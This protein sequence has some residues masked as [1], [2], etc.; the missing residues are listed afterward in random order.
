ME[1]YEFLPPAK[2]PTKGIDYLSKLNKV[3]EEKEKKNIKILEKALSEGGILKVFL[4]G[5]RLRI[6]RIDKNDKEIA[7]GEGLNISNAYNDL[8]ED[9][10]AGGREYK[11]V[12]GKLKPHY[13]EAQM[14]ND[15]HDLFEEFLLMGCEFFAWKEKEQYI[16]QIKGTLRSVI[17]KEIINK[18]LQ[19]GKS[20]EW[21]FVGFVHRIYKNKN[22]FPNGD[23]RVSSEIIKIPEGLKWYEEKNICKTGEGSDLQT[24]I[25]NALNAET[26]GWSHGWAI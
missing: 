10:L 23:P 2:N 11:S 20:V 17:P 13:T 21:E 5:G 15:I 19:T 16:F 14:S 12:Y 22:N 25:Q 4:S 8:T 3:T 24:A 1:N 26:K 6:A 18:V 7:Y 9:Y